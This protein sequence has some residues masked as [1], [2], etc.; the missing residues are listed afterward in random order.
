[1]HEEIAI[2]GF[3]GQGVLFVGR[4]LVEA[5]LLE[6]HEVLYVPSY[7]AEKRGGN[8]WC[9]VTISDEKIGALF[10]A[11]PTIAIAM[12]PS[13]LAK[14]EPAMKLESLLV[15]N[16]SLIPSKVSR[17]DISVVYVPVSDLATEV[18]DNSVGNLVIL[19]TLLANRPVVSMSSIIVVM[20]G[21]LSKNQ[22][23]LEMNKR[24]L[25]QGYAWMQKDYV[26]LPSGRK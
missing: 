16:Q 15:V 7:A 20:D 1:V 9:N 13:S 24:A 8:V 17:E 11:R 18:G 23:R 10:I 12:N 25:N 19:G 22:E 21:M 4:L 14:F 3:G 2:A 26:H 6:G 5:G